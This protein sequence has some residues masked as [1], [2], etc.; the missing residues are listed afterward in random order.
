H[1]VGQS[2]NW[3]AGRGPLCGANCCISA[4][5][6]NVDPGVHQFDR[7]LLELLCGQAVTIPIDR[8]VLALGKSEPPQLIEQRDLMRRVA[9]SG[10]EATQAIN[11]AGFLPAHSE[12]PRR[13]PAQQ[14]D[15]RA[16]LHIRGH[17]ITSS[18][19]A[20]SVGGISRPS[21]FATIR[22]TT[23]SNLVGCSTGMS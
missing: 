16:A 12:R 23:R 1:I 15:E 7:M 22:L 14:R 8:E 5:R 19:R 13:R 17:S 20:S 2:Q 3:N 18:A 4:R 11:S 10:V 9:W 6:D 21:A